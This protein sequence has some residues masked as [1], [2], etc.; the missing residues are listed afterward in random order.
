LLW[1]NFKISLLEFGMWAVPQAHQ[2]NGKYKVIVGA[3]PEY[4]E[5]RTLARHCDGK[6]ELYDNLESLGQAAVDALRAS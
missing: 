5:R 1:L 4:V 2:A 3:D 6:Y